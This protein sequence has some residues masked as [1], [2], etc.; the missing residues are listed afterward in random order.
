MKVLV[1]GATGRT[2][3]L[4]VDEALTMGHEVRVLVRP[5]A[6]QRWPGVTPAG[7]SGW[8][9]CVQAVEGDVLD[10]SAVQRAVEGQDAVV[11]CVGGQTPWVPQT[12][13]RAAMRHIVMAMK[14]SGTRR[15]LVVSAM[16][17]GQNAKQAPWWYRWLVVPTFLRGV[18]KDK[19]AMELIVRSSGLDWVIALAPFLT[20]GAKTG[21]VKVLANGETGSEITR[22]DL[23]RWMVEQLESQV[24]VGQAVVMVNS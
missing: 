24:Y 23:A 10:E 6:G 8:P 4:V 2:G 9:G 12:L 14:H 3:R 17:S 1:L 18:I 16:G 22:A 21:K 13:E 11:Q 20:D 19:D 7:R 15:L 5:K